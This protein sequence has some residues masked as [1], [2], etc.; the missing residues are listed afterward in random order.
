MLARIVSVAGELLITVGVLGLLFLAWELWWTGLDAERDRDDATDELFSNLEQIE[1][2]APG[3][4]TGV[5][6]GDSG[7]SAGSDDDSDGDSGDGGG[8]G[9]G[10]VVPEPENMRRF[11]EDGQVMAMVYSPR[12]GSDW[13]APVREGIGDAQLNTTG[14]GHYPSTQ[15]PGEPG[16]FAMAGHRQTYG[17]VLWDQDELQADDR[18]YVQSPDGFYTYAVRSTEIVDPGDSEVLAEVP[19][20]PEETNDDTSWLTLTTCHPP[21]TT[22][23]RMVTHA[24]L[25]DHRS[26]EAGAPEAIADQVDELARAD[27]TSPFASGDAET[28][29]E[30]GR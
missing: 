1:P 29:R 2:H 16:N 7:D 30:E 15:L 11:I 23:Q 25:V 5:T 26:L 28:D 9:D 3:E 10:S 13:A 6:L 20:S 8:D 22:L 21:Y 24:E 14:L 18:I 4:G 19:G 17:H 27:G 12:L